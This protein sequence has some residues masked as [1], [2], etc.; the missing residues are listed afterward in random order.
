M[1][2]SLV[3]LLLFVYHLWCDD[4]IRQ[5]FGNWILEWSSGWIWQWANERLKWRCNCGNLRHHS[6]NLLRV[7]KPTAS[8]STRVNWC[9]TYIT[10]G[11][12]LGH[13]SLFLL[14]FSAVCFF[15]FFFLVGAII[16]QSFHKISQLLSLQ[17]QLWIVLSFFFLFSRRK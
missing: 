15:F 16:S 3:L 5:V 14:V 1:G 2:S 4:N 17:S 7:W 13:L 12:W 11:S 6:L 8:S 10:S 9:M